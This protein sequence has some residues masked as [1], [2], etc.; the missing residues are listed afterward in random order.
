M[1]FSLCPQSVF[2]YVSTQIGSGVTIN[3]SGLCEHHTM[4][5]GQ[6]GYTEGTAGTPCTHEHTEECYAP[7]EKCIHEHMPYCYPEGSISV[8]DADEPICGHVC[9]EENGCITMEPTSCRHEHDKACGYIP[10]TEGTPCGYVCELCSVEETVAVEQVQTMID[11]LPPLEEAQA[12]D[13]ESQNAVYMAVQE[14]YDACTLLSA[15]EAG[16]LTGVEQLT[17]LL[18]WFAGQVAPFADPVAQIG[19]TPFNSFTEALGAAQDGDTIELLADVTV[20]QTV[21]ISSS[22]TLTSADPAAPKKITTGV[23]R[24][25]YLLSVSAGGSV[26][27]ENISIDGGHSN[28]L[29]AQRAAVAVNGGTLTLGSGAVIQNNNNTTTNG[30]GGGVCVISGELILDGGTI[31]G[32]T[33]YF[34]GGVGM[35][36]GAFTA[37]TGSITGNLGAMGG[38]VCVWETAG[39]VDS[40]YVTGPVSFTGNTSQYYA[41]GINLYMK[42]H[43]YL[44]N[45]PTIEGGI[46]L[47]G[48]YGAG[49]H[50]CAALNGA[51][52]DNA[53]IDFLSFDGKAGMLIAKGTDGYKITEADFGKLNYISDTLG[54]RFN[55]DGDVILDYK[56]AIAYELNGGSNA[57]SNPAIYVKGAG[58]PAFADPTRVGYTF[59]GWYADADFSG[60]PVTGIGKTETGEKTLYAKWEES[61]YTVTVQDDGNGTGTAAPASAAE[62]AEITLT[63]APNSGYQFKAWEVVSGGVTVTDNKFILPADNVTVKAIFEANT[64][65]VTLNTNGGTIASGKDVTG[66][67]Y[68][69]STALP[70]ADDMTRTGYTFKGWYADEKF[71]GSPVAEIG[72]TGTGN[73]TFY[74]KWEQNTT[75]TTPDDTVRYTLTFETNG[76][77]SIQAVSVVDGETIDLSVYVPTRNGY[78]FSGWYADKGLT[79]KITEIKP[80]S[81]KTVYAGWTKSAE[82]AKPNQNTDVKGPKTGDTINLTPWFSLL[83]VSAASAGGTLLYSRKKRNADR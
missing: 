65:T 41:D 54:L 66:Y 36:S 40:L 8:D 1:L 64:Y 23:N 43:I 68:G 69:V 70:T 71:S 72:K 63:A 61:T 24:H 83:L 42:G 5:D 22:I 11:A 74:A 19:S 78:S 51:L 79:Q 38:A 12:M 16:Q 81:D 55:E 33:G 35:V 59:K 62:G 53:V 30:V 46:Y 60:S 67:T 28:G 75:P 15:E 17:A 18:D 47:D 31:K 13:R 37:K 34:G 21:K 44:S 3:A 10:A 25:G 32:N 82:S 45:S 80:D 9:S 4:H 52:G 50:A 29:T 27:L 7:V 26:T 49:S 57:Q 58:V 39:K 2:A 6:C 77:S 14:A 76:G 20:S 73:K 56:Y 48:S